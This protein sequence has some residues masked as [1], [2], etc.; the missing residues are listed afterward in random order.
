VEAEALA[1]GN[2]PGLAAVLDDMAGCH[3]RMRA[4]GIIDAIQRVVDEIGVVAGDERGGEM[5]IK[6]R[7]IGL[8]HEFEHLRIARSPDRWGGEGDGGRT[9]Q[10]ITTFHRALLLLAIRAT[11]RLKPGL[12]VE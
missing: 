4:R 8:W 1:Q 2:P 3:L 6:K 7:D 10:E 12:A 5:W 9:G 11:L